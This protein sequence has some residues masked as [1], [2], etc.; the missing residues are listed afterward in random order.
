MK[1]FEKK[2]K[3]LKVGEQ[4]NPTQQQL[5]TCQHVHTKTCICFCLEH[6]HYQYYLFRS[7]VCLFYPEGVG[8][9]HCQQ[10]FLVQNF[11]CWVRRQIQPI[12]ACVRS[13]KEK[14]NCFNFSQIAQNRNI[15]PEDISFLFKLRF[16]NILT[17]IYLPSSY[18]KLNEKIDQFSQMRK[19]SCCSL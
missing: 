16:T 2:P 12:K 17:T 4:S 14:I 13:G 19:N 15:C 10:K 18:L 11:W 5:Y 7:E 8:L 1:P 3:A 9:F 6:S